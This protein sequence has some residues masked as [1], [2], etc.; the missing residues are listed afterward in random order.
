MSDGLNIFAPLSSGEA[1]R[2]DAPNADRGREQRFQ[3]IVPPPAD[4]LPPLERHLTLG[5]PVERY[6][7]TDRHGNL[8]GYICRFLASGWASY[9]K[10]KKTFRPQR[11]GTLD[12]V[13][14]WHWEKGWG[15]GRPLYRLAELLAR[16]GGPVLVFEGEKK[17]DRAA[18][19]FPAFAAT[20]P[21]NGANSPR[22]TNWSAVLGR[23]VIVVPDN[24]EAGRRFAVEV[25]RLCHAAGALS[26]R[27]VRLPA[28]F[29]EKW[30]IADPLPEGETEEALRTLVNAAEPVGADGESVDEVRPIEFSDDELA[31]RFS[32]R[33]GDELR[34]VARFGTWYAWDGRRW[35]ADETLGYFDLARR[36]CRGA[37]DEAR[38][39]I[40]D[41]RAAERIAGKVASATA[42]AATVK[43]AQADPRQARRPDD[44]DRDPWALN[45]P[46]GII[47]LRSGTTRPHDRTAY[48]TKI[49]AAAAAGECPTWLR[50]LHEVT[51]GD[52]EFAAYLRRAAGYCLTGITRE[53]T[54]FFAHGS[55]GN[56]KG[57]FINTLGALLGDY[58]AV[59]SMATFT[60]SQSERHPTDLAMLR[61]AR[62]VIAQETQ[63]GQRWDEAKIKAL[64]GGDPITA[65]FM[66]QDFFT[67]VP[68]FKLYIVGNHCPVLRNVDEAIRR[69][70]HLIPFGFKPPKPDAALPERLKAEWPGILMWAVQGCLEWQNFGLSPPPVVTSATAEYFDAQDAIGR[71]LRERSITDPNGTATTEALYDDWKRW[72]RRANE[73]EGSEKSFSQNL[74]Q[75][76]YARWQHP[77]T[78]R[79]GFKGLRLACPP[80]ESQEV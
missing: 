72:A 20:S 28:H 77:T 47:D 50:F 73:A 32:K 45:T 71:W 11:Y 39:V 80:T 14:G 16:P 55:G 43:L 65:R 79:M 38:R 6:A 70:L 17:A 26:V 12:G 15:D 59:A 61:G 37:S 67:Y 36:V 74:G 7:Y 62:L 13:T 24:D 64:T 58:T 63:E 48:C 9:G 18:E 44:W 33:H 19:I 2:P 10:R 54:L 4:A 29:P 51:G 68:Q 30:D 8:E 57:V 5:K 34:Y 52:D 78:R 1:P 25:I 31:L 22:R 27:V 56:G 42:V 60:A 66:R 41:P 49:T 53:H 21:M 46:H 69:R 3:P 40:N 23:H 76:G 75:R 35:A